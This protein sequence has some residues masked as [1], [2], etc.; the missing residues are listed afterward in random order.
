M[1]VAAAF[2]N[3]EALWLALCLQVC[4]VSFMAPQSFTLALMHEEKQQLQACTYCLDRYIELLEGE[5][6]TA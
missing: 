3:E 6:R 2:A 5:I 1:F 4:F